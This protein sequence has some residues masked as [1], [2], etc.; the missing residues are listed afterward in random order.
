[1]WYLDSGASHHITNNANA[2]FVKHPYIGHET[3]QLGNGIGMNIKVVGSPL[4]NSN[5]F[6]LKYLLHVPKINKKLLSV[7]KFCHD[8]NIFFE[9]HY[10]ACYVKNQ[11][12]QQ[13]ILKENLK[14]GLYVFEIFLKHSLYNAMQTLLLLILLSLLLNFGTHA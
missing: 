3:V 6:L 2:F 4:N 9:F 12:R 8:N 13:T 14:D 10:N 7:S 1:M 5:K 11:V